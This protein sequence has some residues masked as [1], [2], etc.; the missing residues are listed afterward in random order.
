VVKAGALVLAAGFSRRFGS[1]KRRYPIDGEPLLRRTV[2]NVVAA[3]LPCRVCLRP[4]DGDLP[5]LLDLPGVEYIECADAAEGMGSTLA[6]GAAVCEDWEGV[7]VV[8]GDMPWVL[9][10]TLLAIRDALAIDRII[11]PE[12]RGRPGQPVGFGS[13][14]YPQLRRL[15]GDRGGRDILSR[16]SPALV[17]LPVD[18]PGIHR[19]LDEPQR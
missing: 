7:L 16:H 14:F 4:G 11:Q 2:A 18:D 6:Q 15:R 3:G 19:D 5:L 9:P 1:D 13:H 17:R 10:A 12:Y 8:L